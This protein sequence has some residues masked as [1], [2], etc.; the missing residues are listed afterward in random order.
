ML[1]AAFVVAAAVAVAAVVVLR[2][3]LPGDDEQAEAPVVEIPPFTAPIGGPLTPVPV[4]R[5]TVAA[6]SALADDGTITYGPENTID[7][8]PSTAW[9]SDDPAD[10]GRGEVLTYRFSEPIDLRGVG[11]INGYD[12][13]DE[14][15]EANHRIKELRLT[16]DGTVQ[17]ISLDDTPE[18]Q[19][20]RFEFGLTSKVEIEVVD[21]Y[22]GDGFEGGLSADLALSEISFL[23]TSA[24]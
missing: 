10:D 22:E 2:D 11:F 20:V 19:D 5:I 4:E 1:L 3:R 6:T 8:D 24:P 7:A 16:T 21:V 14:I 12:K 15:F 18:P 23:A 9:N 17:L 13:S